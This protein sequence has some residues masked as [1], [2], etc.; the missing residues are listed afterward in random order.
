MYLISP[1]KKQYKA[2][3]HCHS[4]YSD[5]NKTPEELKEMYRDHGYSIL[6]I[7]DHETPKSHAELTE[8]TF[9]ML[10]GYECYIRTSQNAKYDV[11]AKEVHLN[12]FARE[13]ENETI[14][15]YSKPYCKYMSEE[16]QAELKK[17]G[18]ERP[19]EYS[20]EYIN[21]YIA[22][23]NENGYIV[24]YNHPYWSMENEEDVLSYDGLFS[25]EMCNYGSYLTNRLDYCGALY[26]KILLSGKR[27]ACHSA[28]DNHNKTPEGS[29]DF[30]SFGAFTMIMPGRFEYGAVIDAMEKGEMYSSMGPTFNS[31]S[32]D[33]EMLHVECSEVEQIIAYFGSKKPAFLRARDGETITAADLKVPSKAR[34]VRVS[35]VDSKGRFADTRGF[36]REEL[37]LEPLKK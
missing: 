23:A 33:G 25:L 7:T 20:R 29:P 9:I 27:M 37:G 11:Y 16:R 31:V 8:D 35:L 4:I 32:F 10:T 13:P 34:F 30:D 12:L 3:L 1:D 22:T 17:A 2:N 6:A 14:I 24:A 18:D 19:R 15:C 28:D 26:D 5:G 21:E 36:S